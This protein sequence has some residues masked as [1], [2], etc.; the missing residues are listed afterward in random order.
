MS[1]Q[2]R[3]LL[4]SVLMAFLMAGCAASATASPAPSPLDLSAVTD[5]LRRAGIVVVDVADNLNPRD[6]AWQCLPGSF[7]LSRVSQQP[8]PG[9]AQPGDRPSVDILLFSTDAE[10]AAAQSAV[11]AD[12]QVRVQGCGTMVDWVATPHL[13]GAR[14]VLLFIA[15]DD[16]AALAAVRAAAALIGG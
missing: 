14:N 10:R 5:A 2:A 3:A 15:T 7:R 11:G 6:G 8:A 12:G 13:V 9:L 1:R 16:P 4:L